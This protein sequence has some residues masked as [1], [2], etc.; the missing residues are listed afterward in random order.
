MHRPH[1]LKSIL[2][3]LSVT[4]LSLPTCLYAAPTVQDGEYY[5]AKMKEAILEVIVENQDIINKKPD[6]TVKNDKLLP[7]NF[8]KSSYDR[9][10]KIGVGKTFSRKALKGEQNPEV[11]AP[12]LAT[13]LQAG[14]VTTANYQKIINKEPD[15]S[16][17]LKK[18][19]PAV[20]GKLTLE[21]FTEKTDAYMK[22]TTLGKGSYKARNPYNQPNDWEIAAL[23]KFTA[24]GWELNK[25][26]GDMVGKEYRYVKPIYIKKGCLACHGAPIGEKGPY[27]SPKEGYKLND[28]RGGISVMLPLQ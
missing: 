14:R 10:K 18:F 1:R 13:L 23:D 16:V 8:F 28:I 22:Q 24:P 4:L 12:V 3:T 5:F 26:H 15:G 11:I 2:V 25:G 9:F 19:I 7:K 21:K 27:G 17:K 20:F 6:G